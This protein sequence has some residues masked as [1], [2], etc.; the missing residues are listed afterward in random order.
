MQ[1]LHVG[2]S[3]SQLLPLTHPI[4]LPAFPSRLSIYQPQLSENCLLAMGTSA[5]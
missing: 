5:M 3:A 4:T 1:E 2:R